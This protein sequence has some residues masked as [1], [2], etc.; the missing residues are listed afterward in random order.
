[1]S[2]SIQKEKKIFLLLYF[3]LFTFP[4]FSLQFDSIHHAAIKPR[5]VQSCLVWEPYHHLAVLLGLLFTHRQKGFFFR[6]S[7]SRSRSLNHSSGVIKSTFD[8]QKL[9]ILFFIVWKTNGK[10][11]IFLV[12][13]G[14]MVGFSFLLFVASLLISYH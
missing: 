5:H 13:G 4:W 7:L 2:F 11:R 3:C 9:Q 14:G 6:F 12:V 10:A 1:V 8:T